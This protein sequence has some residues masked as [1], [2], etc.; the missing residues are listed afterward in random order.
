MKISHLLCIFCACVILTSAANAGFIVNTGTPVQTPTT[1][2][3]FNRDQY[4]AGRFTITENQQISSVEGYF[5]ND[6]TTADSLVSISIHEDSDNK[7]GIIL[8]STYINIDG[9]MPLGWHGASGLDWELNAGT[10]WVSFIPGDYI[11]GIMPGVAPFPL[12]EYSQSSSTGWA[13]L[14]PDALDDHGIG[15]RLG[16]GVETLPVIGWDLQDWDGDGL[17]SDFGFL[18]DE[19]TNNATG[20]SELAFGYADETGCD[21]ATDGIN[22]IPIAM[23]TGPIDTLVFAAGVTETTFA[24]VRPYVSSD[25]PDFPGSGNNNIAAQITDGILTFNALDLAININDSYTDY[26]ICAQPES[27]ESI[28]IEKLEQLEDPNKWGVIIRYRALH[29]FFGS[30]VYVRLEGVMTTATTSHAECLDNLDDVTQEIDDLQ[31]DI[32]QALAD[33]DGDGVPALRDDCEGTPGGENVDSN[34]CSL[35]QFC[36]QISV[37]RADRDRCDTADFMGD[38]G[39]DPKDCKWHGECLVR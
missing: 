28:T 34:G 8:V 39:A 5:S 25:C 31:D 21:N 20:D 15:L 13:D 16:A 38:E 17:R 12:E 37:T 7:P 30:P 29:D 36:A 19:L 11:D 22:C 1:N 2:Y 6:R 4:Y 32:D 24:D 23:N 14:E 35:E 18:G 27:L 3:L 9:N 33:D 26:R 10:Y